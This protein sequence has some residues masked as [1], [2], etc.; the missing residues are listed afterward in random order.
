MEQTV[1]TGTT[2][3]EPNGKPDD[4]PNTPNLNEE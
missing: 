4:N 2:V 1:N 3:S